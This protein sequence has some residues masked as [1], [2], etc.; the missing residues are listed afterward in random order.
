MIDP[1]V[2]GLALQRAIGQLVNTYKLA[3]LTLVQKADLIRTR[4]IMRRISNEA[5]Q[6]SGEI[7]NLL[8]DAELGVDSS[9][10]DRRGI[11]HPR[12]RK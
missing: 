1:N 4:Q 11:P 8:A 10:E 3:D 5:K 12:K 6:I 9:G 2:I 7:A